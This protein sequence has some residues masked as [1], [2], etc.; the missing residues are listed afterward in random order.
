M[1]IWVTALLLLT[2]RLQEKG[3]DLFSALASEFNPKLASE[4][5]PKIDSPFDFI[6]KL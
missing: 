6:N 3:T 5:N 2:K 4:F 1:S